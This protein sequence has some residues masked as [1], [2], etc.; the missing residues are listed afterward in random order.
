MEESV[1]ESSGRSHHGGGIMEEA[2]WRSHHGGYFGAGWLPGKI[3]FVFIV[4]LLFFFCPRPSTPHFY[5]P[6]PGWALHTWASPHCTL[7]HFALRSLFVFSV[8]Y[9]YVFMFVFL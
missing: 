9:D 5:R 2:S 8:L 3:K 7:L 1:E 6:R 4:C